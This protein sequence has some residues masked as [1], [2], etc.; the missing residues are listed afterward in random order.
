MNRDSPLPN[1]L[2]RLSLQPFIGGAMESLQAR[3][4]TRQVAQAA[5]TVDM[6]VE[7]WVVIYLPS[8]SLFTSIHNPTLPSQIPTRRHHV[9][10]NLVRSDSR[11]P[12]PRQLVLHPRIPAPRRPRPRIGHPQVQGAVNGRPAHVTGSL[13]AP[14][15]IAI[16]II[17]HR[18]DRCLSA[19]D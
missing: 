10:P 19:I 14:K 6:D 18:R 2:L 8:C 16:S 3:S 13:A 7:A 4:S 11:R 12:K 9:P 17:H 5:I 15:I 1:S